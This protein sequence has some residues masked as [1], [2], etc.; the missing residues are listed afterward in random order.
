MK[1]KMH[2]CCRGKLHSYRY[3][4]A[5]ALDNILLPVLNEEHKHTLTQ[6]RNCKSKKKKKYANTVDR[7]S[8]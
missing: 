5:V 2:F 8:G 7:V 6:K 4:V 1:I 3:V